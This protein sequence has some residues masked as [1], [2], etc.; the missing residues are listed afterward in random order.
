[1]LG[2]A[3]SQICNIR[4]LIDDTSNMVYDQGDKLD[5]IGDDL[6]TSYK[7]M[8]MTNEELS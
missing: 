6:F 4:E 2:N 5:I 1:M 7:N 3:H 8:E